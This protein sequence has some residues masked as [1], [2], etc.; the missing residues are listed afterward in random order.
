VVDDQEFAIDRH[1]TGVDLGGLDEPG[2]WA[3]CANQALEPLD[4]DHPLWRATLATGLA[5]GQVGVL[6]VL[7]HALADGIAGAALAQRAPA[8]SLDHPVGPGRRLAVIRRPLE[9]V[10][11]AGHAHGATVNDVLLAAV[12]GG[13]H[14]LLAG[15]GEPVEGLELRVSVPVGSPGRA[16]NAGGSTPMV[17]PLPVGPLEPVARLARVAAVTR[18]AKAGRDRRHRGLLA[19][20][21]LPAGLLRLGIRWLRRHGGTKVNLYVT[22]VPGPPGPLWLAGAR[23]Q[24]AVPIA[25]LVAGVPVAV[26]RAVLRRRAGHLHPGRRRHG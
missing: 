16:R 17:L 26:G 5:G 9:P 4:R 14:D 13:L 19:S 6:V 11:Q 22:N 20:P 1:L 7:H 3:W 23:L 15:R 18:A 25:P 24:A 12:A 2:F 10:R 21:L 8:T